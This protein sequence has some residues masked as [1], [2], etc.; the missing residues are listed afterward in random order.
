MKYTAFIP[1]PCEFIDQSQSTPSKITVGGRANDAVV[2]AVNITFLWSRTTWPSGSVPHISS[3]SCMRARSCIPQ[4]GSSLC[5][6]E[7]ETEKTGEC[8]C[9]SGEEIWTFWSGSGKAAWRRQ[10][11]PWMLVGRPSGVNEG[12]FILGSGEKVS[13]A[14]MQTG[15]DLKGWRQSGMRRARI[16]GA[17][18]GQGRSRRTGRPWNGVVCHLTL[19]WVLSSTGLKNPTLYMASFHVLTW[20]NP[21]HPNPTLF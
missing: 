21:Q 4:H 10:R 5:L 13:W 1:C 2:R 16:A 15:Q 17:Q 12:R 18:E 14:V 11:A 19:F 8:Y 7:L 3:P 6:L 20:K 9:D